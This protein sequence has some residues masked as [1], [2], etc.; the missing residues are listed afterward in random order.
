MLKALALLVAQFVLTVSSAFA[1]PGKC[2]VINGKYSYIEH[3]DGVPTRRHSVTMFTRAERGVFSY[4]VDKNGTFQVADGVARPGTAR[5][6]DVTYR[7][8]CLEGTL[9]FETT[10]VGSDAKDVRKYAALSEKE[11]LVETGNSGSSGVYVL[12]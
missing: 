1:A 2:P 7:L 10:I 11:L 6:F 3:V 9:V 5:G 12:Q 4:T 8:T